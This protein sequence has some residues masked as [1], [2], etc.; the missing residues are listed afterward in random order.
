VRSEAVAGQHGQHPGDPACLR[1]G[2]EVSSSCSLEVRSASLSNHPIDIAIL[3]PLLTAC[4]DVRHIE[5][6]HMDLQQGT[7]DMLVLQTLVFAPPHGYRIANAIAGIKQLARE[8]SEMGG[9]CGAAA[10]I[11]SPAPGASV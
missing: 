2:V 5:Y 11:M 3:V 7:L 4:P 9:F 1:G 6:L 10:G 8:P